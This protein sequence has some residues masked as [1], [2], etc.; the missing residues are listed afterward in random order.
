MIDTHAHLNFKAFQNDYQQAIQRAL[1]NNVRSIINVGSNFLTSQKAIEIAKEHNECYAA[2]GLHPIHVKDEVF[3][4]NKY[5]EIVKA[6]IDY[7]KAIGETGLDFYHSDKNKDEQTKV[8]KQHIELAHTFNLPLILHCRGSKESPED[9]YLELL[10]IL[11]RSL[12][13][14]LCIGSGCLPPHLCIG[15]GGLPPHHSDLSELVV[16]VI[17]CFSSNW[18]IAQEYLNLGLYIGFTGVIT[19]KNADK[20]LLGVVKNIP[21]DKILVETDCPFLSPEPHRGERN[22]P[23]YVLF[24]AQK[25]A[26]IKDISLE[27]VDKTTTTNAQKLF[28]LII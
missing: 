15:S 20:Q 25:I 14:H 6:N 21:L 5:S 13:P 4:I 18:K 28:K 7:I 22:E 10:K 17:H 23:G 8:L 11:K 26:E 19:F 9:A 1:K 2:I 3:D 16:G 24:T 12:P 27:D